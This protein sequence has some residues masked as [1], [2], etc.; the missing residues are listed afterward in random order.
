MQLPAWTFFLWANEIKKLLFFSVLLAAVALFAGCKTSPTTAQLDALEQPNRE[1]NFL[2][3]VH[4]RPASFHPRSAASFPVRSRDLVS[5]DF[6]TGDQVSL[7]WGL[8][9][10]EDY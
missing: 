8:I 2:G 3:I 6:M 9:S 4:E 1:R 10:F 7:F 5:R